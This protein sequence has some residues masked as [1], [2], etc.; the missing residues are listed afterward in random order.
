MPAYHTMEEIMKKLIV[1][2]VTASLASAGIACA[3]EKAPAGAELL[4]KRCS[5]CHPSARA[6]SA[7]KSA[8]QWDAIVTRMVGKGA[9]LSGDEKKALVDYLAKT[10]K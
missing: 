8:A 10:Y 6:K 5:V 7:K 1:T 2:V 9:K 3:A 4:E